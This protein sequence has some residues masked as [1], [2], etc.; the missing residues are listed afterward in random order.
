MIGGHDIFAPGR[1]FPEDI[2]VLLRA[3]RVIWP[4]GVV[5]SGDGEFVLSIADALR[6]SWPIPSELFIYESDA[7]YKS[8]TASGLT[9]ENADAM[10][11]VT[12]EDD[13]IAFVVDDAEAP[14]GA[15]LKD[16]MSAVSANR[17]RWAA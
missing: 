1:V 12:L 9:D 5:E 11:S 4:S 3:F 15:M 13:G 8:W 2:D 17:R 7:A 16:V 14:T 10:I 6:R